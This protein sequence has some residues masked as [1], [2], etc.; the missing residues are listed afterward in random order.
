MTLTYTFNTGALSPPDKS[1]RPRTALR[2]LE[3]LR[4]CADVWDVAPALLTGERRHSYIT[5]AR[6][7]AMALLR[8]EGLTLGEIAAIFHRDHSSVIHALKR[9]RHR[10][11]SPAYAAK[12][13]AAS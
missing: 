10:L 7:A 6:H 1:E 11:L 8:H 12:V 5:E 4:A 9:H 13:R 3:I 2:A